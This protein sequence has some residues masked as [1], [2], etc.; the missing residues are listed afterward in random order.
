M[1]F[2][3]IRGLSVFVTWQ[4]LQSSHLKI[5]TELSPLLKTHF[6]FCVTQHQFTGKKKISWDTDERTFAFQAG[7]FNPGTPTLQGSGWHA[8]S[9]KPGL[10]VWT[11]APSPPRFRF[12]KNQQ[13]RN[14]RGYVTVLTGDVFKQNIST[15]RT[16]CAKDQSRAGEQPHQGVHAHCLQEESGR[17]K[18]V[19][20]LKGRGFPTRYI[21]RTGR[22][23]CQPS[24]EVQALAG[25]SHPS[26]AAPWLKPDWS[27]PCCLTLRGHSPHTNPEAMSWHLLPF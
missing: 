13:D 4:L 15:W 26:H 17:R 19:P 20:E 8:N 25:P 2:Q 1:H 11:A 18:D 5:N 23:P 9:R 14:Q 24:P 7:I 21:S 3:N 22:C 12:C 10:C 6:E 16:L 27:Q